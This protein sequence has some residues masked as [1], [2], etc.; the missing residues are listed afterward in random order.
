LASESN[1]FP[2]I[3][4][5]DIFAG[6]GGL[7]EG[8]SAFR[9]AEGAR[10]FRIRLSIEK[11]PRAHRTLR[12]RAFFRQFADGQIPSNYYDFLSDTADS[13]DERLRKLFDSHPAAATRADEEARLAELGVSSPQIVQQLIDN[14]LGDSDL[15]ALIGGPPCQAYSLVGRSRN[16]GN[17]EY[18]A[19]KDKEVISKVEKIANLGVKSG[20]P[21]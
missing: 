7:S 9:S 3:P 18:V 16:K 6:P 15:W 1:T 14:S 12:L 17:K 5:I 20:I 13:L 4:V 11:D 21:S 2:S 10:P 19:K 8:F